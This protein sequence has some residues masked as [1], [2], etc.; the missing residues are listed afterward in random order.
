MIP[1]PDITYLSVRDLAQR[2]GVA[3]S[4]VWRWCDRGDY[5][6]PV[7]LTPGCTRWRM[8]DVLTWEREREAARATA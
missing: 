1:D 5:P 8:A 3:P 7:S 6:R 4:T 2:Y